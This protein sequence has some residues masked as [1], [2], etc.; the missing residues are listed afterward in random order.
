LG[1][2]L[3]RLGRTPEAM[4]HWERALQ[5]KPDYAGAHDAF[6]KALL[7]EGNVQGSLTHF[8]QALK[9]NPDSAEV[10]N[11]LAWVL[12]SLAPADGGDAARAVTL[13]ERACKLTG[14]R[15]AAYLDTLGAAYAAAGR[16]DQAIACAQKAIELARSVGQ[17]QVAEEIQTH[18]ELYRGGKAYR[19]P[20]HVTLPRRP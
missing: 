1:L 18:L 9:L 20:A 10:Q 4:A 5:T 2:A 7:R 13:A 15:V 19:Q 3:A 8:E 17:L 11:N 16:F 12:A 14:N 6:G